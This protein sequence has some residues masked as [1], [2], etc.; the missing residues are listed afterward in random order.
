MIKS[1]LLLSKVGDILDKELS[2]THIHSHKEFI[3]PPII[4][5]SSLDQS[6]STHL[7]VIFHKLLK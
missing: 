7:K 4:F 1:G 3:H 6:S 5:V 2:E